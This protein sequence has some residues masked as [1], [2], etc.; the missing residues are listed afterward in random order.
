MKAQKKL[1]ICGHFR[2]RGGGG[3]PPVRNQLGFFVREKDVKCFETEKY[4]FWRKIIFIWACLLHKDLCKLKSS[5]E[6]NTYNIIFDTL[7]EA[8]S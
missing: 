5:T 8:G 3:Q 7:P 2:T 4:V 1:D 6:E